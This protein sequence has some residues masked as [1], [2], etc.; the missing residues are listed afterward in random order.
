M[1]EKHRCAICDTRMIIK[2]CACCHN[3][4]KNISKWNYLFFRNKNNYKIEYYVCEK[5]FKERNEKYF[6]RRERKEND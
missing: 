2:M 6:I 5:C 3:R 1:R 4:L